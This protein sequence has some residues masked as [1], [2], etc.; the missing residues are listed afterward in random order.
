[1]KIVKS[2]IDPEKTFWEWGLGEDG[3]LYGRNSSWHHKK[4]V[5]VD[6]LVSPWCPNLKQ[7]DRIVKEFGH[8]L[9]WL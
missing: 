9:L 3:N 7:M 2:F 8:F 4:F 6:Q 1:M 5:M